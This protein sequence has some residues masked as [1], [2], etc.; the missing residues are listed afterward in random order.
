MNTSSFSKFEAGRRSG[1]EEVPTQSVGTSQ[2]AYS[3]FAPVFGTVLFIL[4]ALC[5][6]SSVTAAATTLGFQPTSVTIAPDESA[7]I[8]LNVVNGGDV[9]GADIQI[10]F[11]SAVIAIDELE[12]GSCPEPGLV[13]TNAVDGE[14]ARYVV[15]QLNPQE[16]CDSGR[17]LTLHLT[18]LAE[19]SSPLDLT[20]SILSS[21]DGEVLPY[22]LNNGTIVCDAGASGAPQPTATP[23]NGL[24]SISPAEAIELNGLA[25]VDIRLDFAS[26]LYGADISL[27]FDPAAVRVVDA[28]TATAG[29]QITAGSCPARGL[30]ILNEVDNATGAIRYALT[31]LNPQPACDGGVVAH[32]RFACLG[33]ANSPVTVSRSLVSNTEGAAVSHTTRDGVIR[34]TQP[35]PTPTPQPTP[36]TPIVVA[37]PTATPEPVALRLVSVLPQQ[38]V[39]NLPNEIYVYGEGFS[40][41]DALYLG[42]TLLESNYIETILSAYHSAIVPI[43]MTAGSYDLRIVRSDLTEETLSDAYFVVEGETIDDLSALASEFWINPAAPSAGLTAEIGLRVQRRG[44]D[45]TVS[46]VQ[47]AFYDGDPNGSGTLIGTGTIA[48]LV[49]DQSADTTSVEWIPANIGTVNLF[50]VIDANNALDENDEGNNTVQREVTVLAPPPEQNP[51]TMQTFSINNGAAFTT[52]REVQFITTATDNQSGMEALLYIEFAYNQNAKT[53]LPVQN[54]G[55][56]PYAEATNMSWTLSARAGAKFVQ[57]WASDSV[58]NISTMP[59]EQTINLVL[60]SDHLAAGQVRVYRQSFNAGDTI[61]IEL[62]SLSGDADL[63]IWPPTWP[64]DP[65]QFSV[66]TDNTDVVSFV[67][68]VSGMYQ[69]EAYGFSSADYAIQFNSSNRQPTTART[70]TSKTVQSEPVTTTADDPT[71]QQALPAPPIAESA[72]SSIGSRIGQMANNMLL[73]WAVVLLML[74]FLVV[75]QVRHT[76]T[77]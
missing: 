8:A 52:D 33:T 70:I 19:G 21:A 46:N 44:G 65:V 13:V 53:W 42:D 25:D 28:D 45:G 48:S 51:P 17:V 74:T 77:R 67:A 7:E 40:A 49:V 59:L 55:W 11:D 31:Q 1:T 56:L 39:N 68:P 35:A 30:M 62:E 38:G 47:V 69:I 10:G 57:A 22:T 6:T 75:W 18:C 29:V 4:I 34:C 36:T 64:D 61:V 5:L 50:A 41:D 16:A 12:T 26:D 32:V 63:Y 71:P 66:T 37:T 3:V 15:T 2:F 76:M 72:P 43:D 20:N 58:G 73:V 23:T 27:T 60:S 54:S 24:L 14:M 9:Y